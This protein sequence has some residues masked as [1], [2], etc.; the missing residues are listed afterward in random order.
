MFLKFI[1]HPLVE[2]MFPSDSVAV[3]FSGAALPT[4]LE[5][6]S[7][8]AASAVGGSLPHTPAVKAMVAGIEYLLVARIAD[9]TEAQ[10]RRLAAP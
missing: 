10:A 9:M 7:K 5:E 6:I 2:V 4:S 1:F 3:R 8:P